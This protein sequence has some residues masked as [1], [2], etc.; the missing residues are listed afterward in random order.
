MPCDV[1]GPSSGLTN[2]TTE[3]H[4]VEDGKAAALYSFTYNYLQY[5]ALKRFR[6]LSADF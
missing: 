2:S 3:L 4:C 5:L 6:G 1:V